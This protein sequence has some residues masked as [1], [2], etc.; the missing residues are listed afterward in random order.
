MGKFMTPS[1]RELSYTAPYMHNGMIKTLEDVVG[2]YNEGGGQDSH[3]SE[4]MKPLNLSS[5]EQKD[6]VSFLKA[7]SGDRL[8]GQE[9]VWDQAY[10]A[11]YAPIANWRKVRN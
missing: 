4:L 11:E 8:E 1:L 10:P 7:L 5:K 2:F 9:F 6:L 3:K